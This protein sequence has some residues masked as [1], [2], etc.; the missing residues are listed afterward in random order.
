[1][2]D[3]PGENYGIML[4]LETEEFYRRVLFALSDN[5]DKLK[6]PGLIIGYN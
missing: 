5:P 3:N 1:M 4:Q 2:I 6:H